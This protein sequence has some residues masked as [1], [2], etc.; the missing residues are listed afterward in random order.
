[1]KTNTE[2]TN[3]YVVATVGFTRPKVDDNQNLDI[4]LTG[5]ACLMERINVIPVNKF[6]EE[7]DVQ[8]K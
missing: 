4:N 1:M 5:Y 3:E 8:T 7:K 6:I 2:N